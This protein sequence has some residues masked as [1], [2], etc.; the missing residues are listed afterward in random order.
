MVVAISN[1]LGLPIIVF[2][3][4]SHYPVIN[5]APRVCRVS[6]PLFVHSFLSP[7]HYDAVSFTTFY[8]TPSM[9]Q[10]STTETPSMTEQSPVE[11]NITRCTCG[12]CDKHST[13][14]WCR[15]R[16]FKYT[17]SIRC[18]CLLACHSCTSVCTCHNCV[19]PKGIRPKNLCGRIRESKKHAWS[20]KS[21]MGVTYAHQ[22]QENVVPG[23][24]MQLEYLLVS[25]VLHYCRQNQ[26]DTDHYSKALLIMCG[27][28]RDTR[29]FTSPWLK[30]S[31]R[32]CG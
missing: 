12:K 11:T 20:L 18:P 15:I 5:I 2:P 26:I 1:A 21:V 29:D 31:Y 30:D 24:R 13:A 7:G 17:T 22:K 14:Q 10:P 9:T 3:S 8:Q 19:N 4:A 6:I 32:Y 23:P 16:H 25:E 28:C 27:A